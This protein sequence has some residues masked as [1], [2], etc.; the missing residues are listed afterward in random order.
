MQLY[1]LVSPEWVKSDQSEYIH[2]VSSFSFLPLL[3]FCIYLTTKLILTK[4]LSLQCRPIAPSCSE[5]FFET[6]VVFVLRTHT[7]TRAR[8]TDVGKI[9]PV[10]R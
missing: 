2:K 7:R 6:C 4:K 5:F 8:V 1:G 3:L 9:H 10:D